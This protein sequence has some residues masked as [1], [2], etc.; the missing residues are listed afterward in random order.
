[1]EEW[2]DIP[3]Y[4]GIYAASN[5]G[6][7]LSL[8]RIDCGGRK[9]Q[10]GILAQNIVKGYYKTGLNHA[11]KRVLCSVHRLVASAFIPNVDNFPEVNH[12]DENPLNNCVEN[13]EWCT[14]VYNRNY[15]T[16][17]TRRAAS[18]SKTMKG[19]IPHPEMQKPT[20]KIDKTTG[21]ILATYPSASEAARQCGLLESKICLVCN[22][23]RYTTGGY[24]WKYI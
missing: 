15:G 5:Y 19:R 23:K 18:Q 12:K 16:A 3:G 8:P 22:G 11:G 9:W 17:I 2:R 6:R 10:G 24:K 14:G 13:L 20:A 21:A 1:M 7:V 4:E